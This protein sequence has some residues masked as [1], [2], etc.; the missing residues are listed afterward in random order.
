MTRAF[1][2][3]LALGAS[4]ASAADAPKPAP[5]RK[6]DAIGQLESD[7]SADASTRLKHLLA[8]TKSA[9]QRFWLVRA[10]AVR[11]KEHKD[12]AALETLLAA[13]GDPAPLVRGSAVRSL[14]AFQALPAEAVRKD[15]LERLDRA[16][17]KA[18]A[19]GSPAVRDGARDLKRALDVFRDPVARGAPAP[20]EAPSPER[21]RLAR[22]LGLLWLLVLP[23]S[24]G[25]WLV[26]GRP[27]FDHQAPEG[28][29]AAKA[30]AELWSRKGLAAVCSVLWVILAFLFIG[31][32]FEAI[33]RVLGEH[34]GAA[35]AWGA[36]YLAA[37]TCYLLPAA[38]CSAAAARSPQGGGLDAALECA[39]QALLLTLGAAFVLG[40]LELAYRVFWRRGRR[41]PQGAMARVLEEGAVRAVS[42]AC[43]AVA[44]EGSGIL[45]A[46]LEAPAPAGERLPLTAYDPRFAFLAAAPAATV[47]CALAAASQSVEWTASR[48]TVLLAC[49]LWAWAVLAGMLSAVLAALQGLGAGARHR[50]Q[51]GLEAPPNLSS[52]STED[53]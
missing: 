25:L 11:V 4:S 41:A 33:A 27:V 34:D 44:E 10:L 51:R 21:T 52:L 7:P 37:W 26:S 22:A 29:R 49:A 31:W 15:W 2:L 42:R 14:A 6:G 9:D 40:P 43:A 48:A 35:G 24:G 28:R 53:A 30:A 20:P 1:L 50:A 23:L 36:A 5:A 47:L 32:G 39:P 13:A 12:A 46:L 3:A 19:D 17:Q 45:P 16:A 38:F 18:A 8:G